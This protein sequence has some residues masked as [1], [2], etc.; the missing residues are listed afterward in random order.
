MSVDSAD[1]PPKLAL[2]L[3]PSLFKSVLFASAI[4]VDSADN[5]PKSVSLL[6][7]LLDAVRAIPIDGFIVSIML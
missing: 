1:K 4:S 2:S 3:V 7:S 6:G 5:P